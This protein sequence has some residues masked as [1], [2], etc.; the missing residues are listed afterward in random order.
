MSVP[1]T[2]A[3]NSE[4][5]EHRL[6]VR[7]RRLLRR[8]VLAA[9]AL[10]GVGV[11]AWGLWASAQTSRTALPDPDTQPIPTAAPPA[12]EQPT[13][14]ATPDASAPLVRLAALGDAGTRGRD[15]ALVAKQIAAADKQ[16]RPFDAL[17]I[18]GDL[19]Y[20]EGEADLTEA[21]V[22]HP[23]AETFK[24]D[25]IIPTVGNHDIESD[26]AN[27]IMRR[28]GRP[29]MTFSANVGPVQVLSLNSNSVN[30]NQTQWL[31]QTLPAAASPTTWVIPLLHHPAYSSGEHGS[32][33]PVQK[34]WSP[35]FAQYGVKLVLAG[36]DHNYE[37]TTPQGG[38]TYITTGGGGAELRAVG[39][40]AFTATSARKHH[41]V[42]LSVFA[43]RIEGRA[44]DKQGQ[45]FDTF[46][47]TRTPPAAGP[48]VPTPMPTPTPTPTAD[49]DR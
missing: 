48:P 6:W 3:V 45:V 19:V 12:T 26:E 34:Q 38:V 20:E 2:Q 4:L 40:S 9:F 44:I 10:A 29:G 47:I 15:Q 24:V 23:Y 1:Y 32:E 35:L 27:E 37:R 39:R 5:A 33:K 18:A 41:F 22:I 30:D 43:D 21:S 46:T 28:L 42:D 16:G 17:L 14:G 31:R 7:R 8:V 49:E 11:L 25:E 36:H 13:S